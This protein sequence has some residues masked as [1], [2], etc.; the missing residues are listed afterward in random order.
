MLKE[1]IEMHL[2]DANIKI[3]F[4]KIA[5]KTILCPMHMHSELELV[6]VTKGRILC[7]ADNVFLQVKCGE[8]V[9]FNSQTAHYTESV[10]EDT[11]YICIF[12]QKPYYSPEQTKY[13]SEFLNKKSCQYH[14]FRKNDSDTD[15][16][17]KIIDIMAYEYKHHLKAR[18][19]ALLARKHDILTLLYRNNYLTDENDILNEAGIKP[20]LTTLNY[21]EKNYFNPIRLQDISNEVNLHKNYICNLFN[22]ITG[23]TITD[24]I[25]HVRICEAKELL[26]TNLPLNEIAYKVGF[27]SQSYFNK[28]FKKQLLYT[29]LEYKKLN[30]NA[31][32]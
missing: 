18:E 6:Y 14:I 20:I 29:P 26:R 27:S 9:F 13:L 3:L 10:E 8:I 17:I 5:E 25:A 2:S 31:N 28:V 15:S 22:K 24:Y 4:S 32:L 21:I 19:Y 11:E 1:K 23:K 30:E 7:Y 12:I 16:L